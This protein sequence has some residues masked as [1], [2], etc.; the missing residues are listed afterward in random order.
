M[1]A[2]R[3]FVLSFFGPVVTGAAF[4]GFTLLIWDWLERH[5]IAPLITML[6]GGLVLALATRWYV[7]SCVAV[8][9]P[10]CGEKS[11]EIPGRANRFMCRVCGKDH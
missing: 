10:F 7:R 4:C 9:C 8:R 11:Y 5:H 1:T 3:H 2:T 6:V